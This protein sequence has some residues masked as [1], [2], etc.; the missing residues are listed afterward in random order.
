MFCGGTY[1]L[2]SQYFKKHDPEQDADTTT[3]YSVD[4]ESS[5]DTVPVEAVTIDNLHVDD[6]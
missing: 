2:Y 5:S 6:W 3:D 1:I 4:D